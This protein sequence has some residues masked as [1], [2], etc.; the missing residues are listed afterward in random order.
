MDCRPNKVNDYIRYGVK[1]TDI[2]RAE[3][4][5]DKLTELS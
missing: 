3:K 5:H 2:I 4:E 1:R